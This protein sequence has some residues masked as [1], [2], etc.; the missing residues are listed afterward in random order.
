MGWNSSAKRE[1]LR[2]ISPEP[3]CNFWKCPLVSIYC[4]QHNTTLVL[5]IRWYRITLSSQMKEALPGNLD[6]H[7]QR[8]SWQKFLS[9]WF[10]SSI[11]EAPV[12]E[13]C[14][15]PV[16]ICCHYFLS[17]TVNSRFWQLPLILRHFRYLGRNRGNGKSGKFW[18]LRHRWKSRICCCLL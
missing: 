5:Y 11:K 1:R 6:T 16:S 13:R 7:T 12:C 14:L 17:Y 8:L 10:V 15:P 18:Q 2:K 4:W 9:L 3:Q